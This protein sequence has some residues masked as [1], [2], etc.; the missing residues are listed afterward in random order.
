MKIDKRDIKSIL[1]ITL[2]NIGDVILTTPVIDA[3]CKNFPG[4]AIDVMVSLRAKEIFH[5]NS[6]IR[7]VMVYNKF[8]S[9]K[10]KFKLILGLRTKSYDMVID[11]RHTLV[12]LFL[13]SRY[14][15]SL[16]FRPAKKA[17]YMKDIHL[18]KLKGLG[19]DISDAEFLIETKKEDDEY[20]ERVL[21]SISNKGNLIVIA[22]GARSSVKRWEVD[23]FKEVAKKLTGDFKAAIILIG[24]KDDHPYTN[25][26]A[27]SLAGNFLNLSGKTSLMQLAAL[28]KHAKLLISNDSAPMHLATALKVPVIAIFG[29]TDSRKYAPRRENDIVVKKELKCAPC[30]KAQCRFNHECLKGISPE[31]VIK[32]AASFYKR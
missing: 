14:R 21:K 26:I 29:P 3:L 6:K 2:S 9:F 4:A 32:K 25:E 28:L 12:P 1:V 23:N 13:N 22:P 7:E 20:A 31:N 17:L 15:T 8:S 24:D 10:D 5:N 16:F 27:K 11:L 19:I 30:E 18:S